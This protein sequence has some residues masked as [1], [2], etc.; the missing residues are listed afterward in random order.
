MRALTFRIRLDCVAVNQDITNNSLGSRGV[1][2]ANMPG[3]H[4]IVKEAE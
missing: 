1:P 4:N 3:D 2:R